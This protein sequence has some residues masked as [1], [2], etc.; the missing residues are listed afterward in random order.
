MSQRQEEIDKQ[1]RHSID[2][3]NLQGQGDD[4]N[5]RALEALQEVD[6]PSAEDGDLLETWQSTVNSTANI[7]KEKRM[8]HEWEK[9]ISLI[10]ELSN[11]PTKDGMHGS[12]QGWAHGDSSKA[13]EPMTPE[14]RAQ[15]EFVRGR[16]QSGLATYR[17]VRNEIGEGEPDDETTVTINGTT[18]DYGE[19]PLPV[20]EAQL[21]D[22]RNDPEPPDGE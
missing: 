22:A 9:E 18:I 13:K 20:V 19:H 5:V 11:K 16:Y 7:S 10:M 17:E 1:R 3:M 6:L 15:E 14:E 4:T 2:Q 12:W 21:A 8:S